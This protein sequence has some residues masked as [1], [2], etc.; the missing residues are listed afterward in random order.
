M[1]FASEWLRTGT[2]FPEFI[3]EAPDDHTGIIVVVPAFDETGIIKLLDSLSAC[4]EPHCRTEVI[5]HINAPP[6][7]SSESIRNNLIARDNIESWK[8]S[9]KGHFFRLYHFYTAE[10]AFRKWGVGLARKSLMDEALRR[11]NHLGKPEGVIANLDA[12]CT[13]QQNYF[14]SIENDL[15]NRP[16]RKGCSIYFEHPV[17]GQEFTPEVYRSIVQYELHLRYYQYALRYT[18]F[19]YLFHTVGSSIAVKSLPYVQAGGMNRRQAGE[20]F[21]FV[22][23]LM[24]AGG[25]F[26]LNSTTVY[27]SPRKSER[28]PFGTGMTITRMVNQDEKQYMTY[29]TKAFSDLKLFFDSI[30]DVYNNDDSACLEFYSGFP[31]SVREFVNKDEWVNRIYEIRSNTSGFASFRKRFFEWFNMFR[32]VKFM[33]SVH[34]AGYARIPVGKAAGEILSMTGVLPFPGDDLELLRYFRKYEKEI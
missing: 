4:K 24:P 12:D 26:S 31:D 27:P 28:V 7:A 22:Q 34:G 2:V 32:I 6:N 29:N 3:K 5:I 13:V 20:D 19:P 10:S 15:L 33:N 11:F 8:R 30:E 18:G 21:Y 17:E 1:A 25:Y 14:Q 9:H 23:K 16:E